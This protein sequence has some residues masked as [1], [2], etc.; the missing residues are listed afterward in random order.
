M[1]ELKG[2]YLLPEKIS[3]MFFQNYAL[4]LKDIILLLDKVPGK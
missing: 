1:Q 2:S 3:V 4:L